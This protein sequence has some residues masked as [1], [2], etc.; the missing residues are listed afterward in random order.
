MILIME[1][2]FLQHAPD[3]AAPADSGEAL[4]DLVSLAL[5]RDARLYPAP[6]QS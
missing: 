5:E 4:L 2:N 1:E 3:D 6:M